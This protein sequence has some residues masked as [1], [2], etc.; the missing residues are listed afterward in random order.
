M[1]EG[2]CQPSYSH[3]HSSLSSVQCSRAVGGPTTRVASSGSSSQ[4]KQ[5]LFN[6]RRKKNHNVIKP[7][8]NTKGLTTRKQWK[9]NAHAKWLQKKGLSLLPQRTERK[10]HQRSSCKH[11]TRSRKARRH[12][13]NL[14][15]Q[16]HTLVTKLRR[17]CPLHLC[18]PV[19]F[20]AF[21]SAESRDTLNH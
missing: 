21:S 15:P 8:S 7:Q 11:K 12:Q 19:Q 10:H 14:N 6:K 20:M 3:A 17:T 1:A 5:K 9:F 2:A 4:A 16:Q 13:P 18:R